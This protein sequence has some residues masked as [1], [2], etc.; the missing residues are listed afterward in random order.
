MQAFL[1]AG[2]WRPSAQGG[3]PVAERTGCTAGCDRPAA[4]RPLAGMAS[5]PVARG[6][7]GGRDAAQREGYQRRGQGQQYR[8][9]DECCGGGAQQLPAGGAQRL[10]GA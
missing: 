8:G 7:L 5:C 6:L 4:M 9:Q 3:R 10:G 2:R 1:A